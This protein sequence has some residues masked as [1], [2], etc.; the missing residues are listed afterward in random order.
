MC[1]ASSKTLESKLKS[2]RRA[3]AKTR[4]LCHQHTQIRSAFA[5]L[6][7]HYSM[8]LV[9][10]AHKVASLRAG[11][12]CLSGKN[13]KK[14]TITDPEAVQTPYN[15]SL[16][17]HARRVQPPKSKILSRSRCTYLSSTTIIQSSEQWGMT[18]LI[19]GCCS[20]PETNPREEDDRRVWHLEFVQ[21]HHYVDDPVGAALVSIPEALLVAILCVR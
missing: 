15:R 16:V 1:S 8:T 20:R 14:N 12:A 19:S 4:K 11:D 18:S 10:A 13:T 17:A 2:D 21:N 6:A 9:L 5:H 7:I 3:R